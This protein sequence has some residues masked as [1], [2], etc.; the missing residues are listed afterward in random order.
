MG[1]GGSAVETKGLSVASW[2]PDEDL[3]EV[4]RSAQARG[5]IGPTTLGEQVAHALGFLVACPELGRAGEVLDLGS[6]GGLPGLVLAAR[7]R[8]V[9]FCLLEGRQARARFLEGAVRELGW[10]GRVT[11]VA[12]RAEVAAQQEE[13]R[14]AFSAV[15][16]R[17][18]ASPAATAECAA[19]FL[20]PAGVLVVA[21][22]PG[23]RA[24]RWPAGP[25]AELG[26]QLVE[27]TTL[28]R[29]FVILRQVAPCP[30]R[31]PRRIGV[32]EHH[33]LFRV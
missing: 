31:F 33:P 2:S 22:P 13:W 32:P 24:E 7:L 10:R 28:P 25:L 12:A 1:S 4:L 30:A 27:V 18:F 26:L 11:I 21:A 23:G 19:G 8:S 20:R 9:R 15:V 5:A 6:G 17:S 16:A 3:L 29:S 14:G